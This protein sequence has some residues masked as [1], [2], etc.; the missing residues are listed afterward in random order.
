MTLTPHQLEELA[1]A[2]RACNGPKSRLIDIVRHL[3]H[4]GLQDQAEELGAIIAELET[5]QVQ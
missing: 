5:W 1:L 4:H 3:E 2:K